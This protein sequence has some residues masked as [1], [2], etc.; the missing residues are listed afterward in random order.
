M[1]GKYD[2]SG[3]PI[4]LTPSEYF[5]TFV[6]N[7]DYTFAPEIGVDAIIK[8][9]NSLENITEVFPD[10]RY[11]DFHMPGTDASSGGLD[12]SSLRLGFEA[13][14]GELKLTVVVHSQWTV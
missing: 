6:L 7:K 9:G 11:V 4:E 12:W 10:V 13:Y 5:R 2:G 14:N 1:W 8:S 3:N